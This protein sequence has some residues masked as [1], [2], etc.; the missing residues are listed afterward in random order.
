MFGILDPR[1]LHFMSSA[2]MFWNVLNVHS[3]NLGLQCNNRILSCN[4]NVNLSVD[5]ELYNMGDKGAK[6]ISI[7]EWKLQSNR[8]LVQLH[9]GEWE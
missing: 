7:A 8:K 3:D 1:I 5:T 9:C 6:C 2:E 4:E